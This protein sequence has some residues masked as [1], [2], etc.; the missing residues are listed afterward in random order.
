MVQKIRLQISF[1]KNEYITNQKQA[2]RHL[3]T[4]YGK[5]M[6]P[7]TFKYIEVIQHNGIDKAV[8]EIG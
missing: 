3:I 5:T 8:N 1:E 2:A 6:N 4:R 7:E